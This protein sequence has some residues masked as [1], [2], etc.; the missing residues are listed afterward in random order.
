MILV[1]SPAYFLLIVSQQQHLSH[2]QLGHSLV[3]LLSLH[4][5]GRQPQS[6]QLI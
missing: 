6:A 3:D 4:S 2:V 1:Q 5:A